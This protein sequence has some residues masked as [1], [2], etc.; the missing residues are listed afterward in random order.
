MDDKRN[1]GIDLLKTISMIMIITMHILGYGGVESGMEREIFYFLMSLSYCGVNCYALISGYNSV[2]SAFKISRILNLWCETLFYSIGIAGI[3][4]LSGGI[5]DTEDMLTCLFPMSCVHY[6]YFTEYFRL[7][8]IIPLLNVFVNYTKKKTVR[9]WLIIMVIICMI[10]PNKIQLGYN[11]VWLA[12]LY[13]CGAYIK[14]YGNDYGWKK[15]I[16]V[17]LVCS[18]ATWIGKLVWYNSARI[19]VLEYT[20]PSVFLAAVALLICFSN[21]KIPAA[22]QKF[23][24]WS[25]KRTFEV[26]LIHT[27]LVVWKV[28]LINRFTYIGN[29]SMVSSILCLFVTV[30]AVFLLCCVIDEMRRCI[31]KILKIKKHLARID[32]FVEKEVKVL[33]VFQKIEGYLISKV[34]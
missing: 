34:H 6:W 10:F 21:L 15:M 18:V 8:I 24:L 28:F 32:G 26:Y 31:W 25:G 11:V 33:P 2:Y 12:V 3:F 29:L 27:H 7:F 14:K 23:A 17:Y 4:L 5:L 22:V 20:S 13:M 1:Y 19:P 9:N 16:L 30:I